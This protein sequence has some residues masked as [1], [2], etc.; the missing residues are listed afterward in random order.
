M[1]NN[2]Y[3]TYTGLAYIQNILSKI[4][5]PYIIIVT[6]IGITGNALT[7]IMLS[8]RSLT[9][10]FNNC[11]LI[12][13]AVTDLLFNLSLLSHCLFTLNGYSSNN[14]CV[15]LAFISHLAELLSA[16]FTAHFTIQRF[17]AVKFPL[18]VFMEKNIH[19]LH[20]IIVSLVILFG[21]SFCFALIKSNDYY[22]CEEEL[23]LKWFISD[24]ILSFVTPFTIIATLNLLIIFHL[25]KTSRKNQRL[26]FSNKQTKKEFLRLNSKQKSSLSYDSNSHSR[27]SVHTIGS[28]IKTS[29]YRFPSH[30]ETND[31]HLSVDIRA[32]RTASI[33]S[34][35]R[36][37]AQSHRVTRML[38]IVSTCFL[39]LNA[40]QHICTISL[41]IYLLKNSQSTSNSHHISANVIEYSNE[42]MST[43]IEN[44]DFTSPTIPYREKST[45]MNPNY[46][47]IMYITVITCQHISYL[48]YSINFFLYSFCGMKFRR[49]LKRFLPKCGN[50]QQRLQKSPILYG[51]HIL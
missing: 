6:L 47:S 49:E 8:K 48:S 33:R 17:F 5:T 41:K 3:E 28:N 18:S 12:A 34:T 51:S 37:H 27:S 50:Y 44:S 19:I 1:S 45:K 20:Y 24:A 32:R 7:I 38:I 16:S 36:S 22:L 42:T 15:L 4:F 40:P 26:S 25:R 29:L 35:T 39:L 23:Q 13:L 43:I 11:T 10:N 9:K 21:I 31:N 46:I 14:F 2:S 30:S